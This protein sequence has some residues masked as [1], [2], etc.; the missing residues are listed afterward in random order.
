VRLPQPSPF[1]GRDRGVPVVL[2]TPHGIE[3]LSFT[4]GDR[5]SITMK[6]DRLVVTVGDV[7]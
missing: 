5:A 4:N 3:H 1:A 6:H 7:E 2:I